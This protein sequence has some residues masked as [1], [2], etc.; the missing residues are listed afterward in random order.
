MLFSNKNGLTSLSLCCIKHFFK[1][2]LF[3]MKCRSLI[4]ILKFG[5][6]VGDF[7][8]LTDGLVG[9]VPTSPRG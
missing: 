2:M 1:I 4:Y 9:T 5:G 6:G 8:S 7:Y 3:E